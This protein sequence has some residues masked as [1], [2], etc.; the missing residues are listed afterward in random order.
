MGLFTLSG[1]WDKVR[2]EP[3][4]KFMV[5]AIT[6][7]GMATL[8]GP[9]LSLKSVNAISHFTDWTIAHV[10]VGALGWNG[11]LTF[12]VLYWLMPKMW[13]TPLVFKKTCRHPFLDWD[14]RYCI[15]CNS[16]VLGGFTQSM[17]WK[18]FTEEGQ[19]KF[20]FLE[21]VT[22]IIPMY[23]SR[24]IGGTLYLAGHSSCSIISLRP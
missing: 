3:V 5:V 20:Q 13:N 1:A 14:N 9:I 4:L 7:Y 23:I 21:T 8:E 12:G 18:T 11:F 19:L 10:H 22:H 24:S 6:C 17:M 16:I 2:E 15:V